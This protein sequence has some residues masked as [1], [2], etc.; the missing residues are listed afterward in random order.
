LEVLV[1]GLGTNLGDRE[2]NLES[3]RRLLDGLWTRPSYSPVYETLPW[4]LLE[5]P[6]FLN[7]VGLGLTD[8]PPLKILERLKAFER[9]LGRRPSP[10]NGP[11]LIDLDLLYYGQWVFFSDRL[12]LPHPRLHLRAFTL[13][14]LSACSPD[15]VHPLKAKTN[16]ELL[17]ELNPPE[18]ACRIYR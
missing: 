17:A 9:E 2:A 5:Q 16:R 4:G 3:A 12:T 15:W 7:Q 18:E 1:V 13:V 11:R 14:P 6:L 8:W 10:L